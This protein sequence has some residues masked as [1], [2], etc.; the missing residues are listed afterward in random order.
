[1]SDFEL[2]IL[3]SNAAVPAYNRFPTSQI[4]QHK[5]LSIL[6]DCGE[7][8]QFQMNTFHVKRAHLDYILISHMHGDHYFGLV[9]L[10]NSLRLN[11]RK[12]D[13]HVYGPPELDPILRL[14][15][16]YHEDQ[17]GFVLHFHPLE[18]GTSY[19]IFETDYLEIFTL[20]MH[21]KIPCN[22]FL[23]K[24]KPKMRKILP[25]A[26]AKYQVPNTSILDI[27]KGA[28]YVNDSGERIPNSLLTEAPPK[29]KSYAYCS[30][31][32]YNE[33]LI[34]LIKGVD[35]LYH[36]STF[37]QESAEKAQLRYHSTTHEA[38][39]IALKAGVKRLILGHFSAKYSDLSVFLDEA[40][41][42]FP[43]T[44]LAIEGTRFPI[45]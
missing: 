30:D 43:N 31:T 36:E 4:L 15:T 25:E 17:E 33:A 1:M 7:G 22:G 16:H 18:F 19:K 9:G 13:L 5:N 40:Q 38:A 12:N 8:A 28:D 45:D 42:I 44:A 41:S 35:L 14:Q 37:L 23:F 24:E 34:P 32:M 10:L 3:G 29:A 11:G 21:H 27:K 26:L 6:I 39:K 2:L 20:P